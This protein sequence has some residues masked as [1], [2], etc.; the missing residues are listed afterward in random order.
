MIYLCTLGIEDKIREGVKESIDSI[1]SVPEDPADE[2]E[3]SG[4]PSQKH[5]N[6]YM[7]TGDHV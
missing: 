5:V 6:V 7:V 2:E 4:R 1:K 3:E